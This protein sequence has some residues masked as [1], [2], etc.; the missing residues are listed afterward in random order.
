MKGTLATVLFVTAAF[1]AGISRA[2]QPPAN[3]LLV[4]EKEQNSLVIVDPAN[5]R[6]VARVPAGQ[7][8]HDVAVA[9]DGTIA[10]ISNYGGNT[11]SRVDLTAQ[12]AL[13]PIDLGALR[14]P[15]GL[16]FVNGKLY[17][18]AEGSKVAGRYDPVT[19]KVDWVMG[20]GQNRTHMV[21]ASKDFRT[22]LTS[23]ISSSTVSVMEDHGRDWT[24]TNVPV[25]VPKD[26]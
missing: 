17:F 10:Y 5:L 11:I 7:N 23:N 25:G 24:I 20:T 21:I 16:E 4:L 14:Q 18:T 26:C 19:Q 9:D 8:P 3:A 15:H 22:V 1:G 12:K 13:A 2:A 6:I